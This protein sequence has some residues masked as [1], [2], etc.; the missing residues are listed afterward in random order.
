MHSATTFVTLLGLAA[1]SLAAPAPANPPFVGTGLPANQDTVP[2]PSP[3][4][5]N[6]P[7]SGTGLP[8]HDEIAAAAPS[9]NP[10]FSGVGLPA[11]D[12]VPAPGDDATTTSSNP[13]FSG[14]GLSSHPND[15][16]V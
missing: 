3:V 10:P 5:S 6:P 2:T 1:T 7:F 11:N 4:A 8:A 14:T 9:N 16:S 12:T 15:E 13:P